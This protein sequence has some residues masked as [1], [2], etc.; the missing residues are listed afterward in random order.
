MAVLRRIVEQDRGAT[1]VSTDD[2]ALSVE[3]RSRIFRF[4]DDVDFVVDEAAGVIHFRSASRIGYSDMGANRRRMEQ[5]RT[6]FQA[7]QDAAAR[8]QK[9]T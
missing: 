4:V 5:I 2:R 9:D 3:Y 6:A 8:E 1:I 7:E